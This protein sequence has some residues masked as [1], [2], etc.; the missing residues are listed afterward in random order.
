MCYKLKHSSLFSF[1]KKN[2]SILY[3]KGPLGSNIIQVPSNIKL[4]IDSCNQI[5]TFSIISL[6]FE[7][8]KNF[9]GFLYIFYN[10]C[11]TLAFGDLIGLNIKGLGLKFLKIHKNSLLMSLGYADSV[12][13][14]IDH[15]RYIFFFKD[16]RN[17][18]IYSTDYC[19]L[20]NQIFTLVG[21]KKP[22]KFRKRENG[23]TVS[24][25]IV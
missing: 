9:R 25:Q 15:N 14:H 2:N 22:N 20:R 6:K 16:I 24:S 10:S 19:F 5:I 11:R 21:L 1:K 3:I 23:I 18:S 13:F 8:K 12:N 4:S 7:K 17:I